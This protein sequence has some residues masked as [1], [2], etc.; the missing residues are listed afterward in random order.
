MKAGDHIEIEMLDPAGRSVF[1][2]IAQRVVAPA[3]AADARA[4]RR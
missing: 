4:P 1:G 3:E 2:K